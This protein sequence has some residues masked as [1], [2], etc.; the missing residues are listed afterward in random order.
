[1]SYKQQDAVPI[2]TT[3]ITN[4]SQKTTQQSIPLLGVPN[5]PHKLE[6]KTRRNDRE[7]QRQNKSTHLER[8]FDRICWVLP[9][10]WTNGLGGSPS[11]WQQVNKGLPEN[12]LH[13]AKGRS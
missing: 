10:L 12:L 13:R 2:I 7:Q 8:R 9:T 6:V 4:I 5:F 3:M 11:A 1:M